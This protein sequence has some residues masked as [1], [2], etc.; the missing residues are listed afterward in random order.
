MVEGLAR[1]IKGEAGYAMK[2]IGTGGSVSLIAEH[3]KLLHVV[4]KDLLLDGLRLIR[5]RRHPA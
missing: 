2:V 3:T 1:R 4:D 5:D